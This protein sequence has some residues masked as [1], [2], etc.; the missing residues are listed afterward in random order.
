MILHIRRSGYW[1]AA[2]LLLYGL[3]TIGY[4]LVTPVFEAPDENHHFYTVQAIAANGRLPIATT[5]PGTGDNLARQEAAQPPLYYL[6]LA[7]LMG[8]SGEAP[9][10]HINPYAQLGQTTGNPNLY[11]PEVRG[12]AVWQTAVFRLRLV[13]VLLG[14]L[15]LALIY[16]AGRLLW[17]P[18]PGR[19]LL[20]MAL[21]AF[22]PQ[23]SFLHAVISNDTL[24][25]F[26][27]SLTIWQVLRLWIGGVSRKRL[28]LLG[29]T[30][31][32]AMLSKT[33]GLLLLVWV[34]GAAGWWWWRHGQQY[35]RWPAAR[36]FI[37]L[38]LL[39][40]FLLAGWWFGR[41]WL[42]YGDPTATTIF[43]ELAGG[44]RALT[45]RQLL[46]ELASVAQSAVAYFG[47]M[48]V[49]PPSLVYWLW[50]GIALVGLGGIGTAVYRRDP[51]RWEVVG[52]LA[53]WVALLTAGWLQFLLRT[54]AEQG[55]LLFPALL[56]ISLALAYG[57]SRWRC[58][59]LAGIVALLTS[60]YVLLV[61]IPTAYAPPPLLA[62]ADLPASARL[63]QAPIGA[64]ELV[65]VGP[66]PATAVPGERLEFTLY[67]RKTD[68]V[69]HPPT[70]VITVLGHD[71]A[72]VGS[73]HTYHG[74]GLFP[75]TLWP[76]DVIIVDSTAVYLESAMTGPT[77][78]RLFVSI[79]DS[80]T[81]VE[82]GRVKI[83]PA[84]WPETNRPVLAQW[85]DG[86]LLTGA[87]VLT[88]TQTLEVQLQWQIT[89][90]PGQALTTFV[91]LGGSTA[92]PIA[93]ADGPPRN[94]FYPT[95]LWAAG[96]VFTDTYTLALPENGPHGRYPLHIGF[97][98]PAT[99]SRLPLY[100][101]GQR[102]PNDAYWLGQFPA[103]IR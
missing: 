76:E 80:G 38:T 86:I 21:V 34:T 75:A 96:E 16:Q 89:Q 48:T 9:V 83:I 23:F 56:P 7:P 22:L 95:S 19:A 101:N 72:L 44:E 71:L 57:L 13:S 84:Q 92:P 8:R 18:Q 37:L 11:V 25:I 20:A 102:Q 103:T 62:T 39:P 73:R 40:A 6:L 46:R 52:I 29:I 67:W 94:G 12:T 60:C 43:I 50:G 97:Y 65:A 1:A 45:F 66:L 49:Q 68:N 74:N 87:Q 2:I 59:W 78:A 5:L 54:P 70:E 53:G 36:D 4:A 31:G 90:P 98:D 61:V 63:L 69:P 77:E 17:P 28:F 58:G 88:T 30:L 14:G 24:I 100:V 82:I 3:L 26:F 42:L 41:N 10:L 64:L 99:G 35:G 33:A 85:G 27:S 32:A 79:L 15:T 51:I 47:W 91:H 55:R 81:A 93:Q